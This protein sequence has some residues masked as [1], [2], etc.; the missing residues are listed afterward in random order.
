MCANTSTCVKSA[1]N[2]SILAVHWLLCK[3]MNK[4]LKIK[5]ENRQSN[6]FIIYKSIFINQICKSLF[7]LFQKAN[8]KLKKRGLLPL[9]WYTIYVDKKWGAPQ[10]WY[11]SR[12]AKLLFVQMTCCPLDC[13]YHFRMKYFF[14]N[15]SSRI[16]QFVIWK[17]YWF[18]IQ[19]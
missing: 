7:F 16:S 12:H 9:D 1:K 11:L 2:S 5:T 6:K 18:L 4:I 15:L 8:T 3:K 19:F 17:G 10:N 14:V 13:A